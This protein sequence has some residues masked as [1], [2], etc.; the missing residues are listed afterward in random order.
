MSFSITRL[1]SSS[2][3]RKK[4]H[5]HFFCFRRL[6]EKI[7]SPDI[8]NQATPPSGSCKKDNVILMRAV[9]W[10][11]L[12]NTAS[13]RPRKLSCKTNNMC[14]M[15]WFFQL[16]LRICEKHNKSLSF[17]A[18]IRDAS[19]N[20]WLMSGKDDVQHLLRIVFLGPQRSKSNLGSI[21]GC[22]LFL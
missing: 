10:A 8:F 15:R 7:W 3:Y 17:F 1:A 19:A 12:H 2:S 20:G 18:A 21:Y 22:F 14:K 5:P 4:S 13:N 9:C 16:L 11:L 6:T